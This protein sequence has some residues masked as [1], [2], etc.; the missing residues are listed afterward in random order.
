MGTIAA[1]T[2]QGIEANR[3]AASQ[4]LYGGGTSNLQ[5]AQAS[6][7]NAIT[8]ATA[9][10]NAYGNYASVI[11]GIPQGN[12]TPNFS[13]TQSS[14]GSNSSSGKGFKLS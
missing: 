3:L 1:Q 4:A 7:G 12:T 8:A 6:A 11:F 10:Q 2:Q 13:G 14:T 9:P 5:N